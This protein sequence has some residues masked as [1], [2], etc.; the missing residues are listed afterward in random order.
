MPHFLAKGAGNFRSSLPCFK[1]KCHAFR[2][3]S[4]WNVNVTWNDQLLLGD[5]SLS[6]TTQIVSFILHT[7][8]ES[9]SLRIRSHDYIYI[10]LKLSQVH[11][12]GQPYGLV[13]GN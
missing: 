12:L 13:I 5:S 11:K 2:P 9:V 10:T 7:D 6:H 3:E 4:K 1:I 8:E